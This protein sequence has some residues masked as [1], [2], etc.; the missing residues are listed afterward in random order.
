MDAELAPRLETERLVLR[1]WREAHAEAYAAMT[2]DPEVMEF[3]GGTLDRGQSWRH[4]ALL[5]GHWTLRGY[6]LWVVEEKAGGA[7]LGR[8]GLW[9]PEG[10]PGL[11]LGW[12]LAREAWGHGFATEAARAAMA[13]GWAQL[14]VAQLISIIAPENAAS[15]RVAERLGMRPGRDHELDGKHVILWEIDR[16]RGGGVIDRARG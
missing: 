2:A 7:F 11:E 12:T 9:R 15:I 3:L 10:W 5:T 1:G 14:D 8:I 16:P 6:G 4:M 13:W